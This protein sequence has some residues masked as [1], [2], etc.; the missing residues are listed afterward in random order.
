VV[1]GKTVFCLELI[2][3]FDGMRARR[4]GVENETWFLFFDEFPHGLFGLC[5]TGCVDD[6]PARGLV[7]WRRP[8]QFDAWF[9]PGIGF[10]CK[11]FVWIGQCNSCGRRSVDEAFYCWDGG[12]GFQDRETA[13]NG[14]SYHGIWV[15]A[16]T[17]V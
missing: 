8:G 3:A 11:F 14:W 7:G 16:K 6:V 17:Y 2:A 13:F 4:T 5:L 9:V 12:C 10:D 15:R 1:S